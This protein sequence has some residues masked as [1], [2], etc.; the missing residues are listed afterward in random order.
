[1]SKYFQNKINLTT[2]GRK[3]NYYMIFVKNTVVYETSPQQKYR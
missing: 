2:T 3:D 1:M